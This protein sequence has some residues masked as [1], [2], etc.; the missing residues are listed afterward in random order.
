MFHKG[1]QVTVLDDAIDGIVLSVKGNEVLI[2]TSD[3]FEM[4]FFV[5]EL[6]KINN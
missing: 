1:D 5:N 3:G 6:I 2:E 4:T